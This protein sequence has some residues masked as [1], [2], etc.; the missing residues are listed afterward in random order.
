MTRATMEAVAFARSAGVPTDIEEALSIDPDS[1]VQ[2][3]RRLIV[4]VEPLEQ[5]RRG[6]EIAASALATLRET[7]TGAAALPVP[8]ALARAFAAAN[9]AVREEN[10]L[11]VGEGQGRR[12]DVGATAVVLEGRDLT[13]AQV[14]PT[15]AVVIQDG[16]GY[17]FPCLDSWGPDYLPTIDRPTPQAE[18]LGYAD[19]VC[20]DLYRTVMAPGDLLILC[21][22]GLARCLADEG[23]GAPA[24]ILAASAPLGAD[25]AEVVERLQQLVE[26][27]DLDRAHAACL[28]VGP[29]PGFDLRLPAQAMTRIGDAWAGISSR[30]RL[31]PGNFLPGNGRRRTAWAGV[32]ASSGQ[33]TSRS[34]FALGPAEDDPGAEPI[35]QLI[36]PDPDGILPLPDPVRAVAPVARN[37][38]VVPMPAPVSGGSGVTVPE[39]T[40]DGTPS[41][42]PDDLGSARPNRANP[43]QGEDLA[44][45][46]NTLPPTLS[47]GLAVGPHVRRS[48][49]LASAQ[50]ATVRVM[51][52]IA[53]RR[54]VAA[55][56]GAAHAALVPGALGMRCYRGTASLSDPPA[57]RLNLPR[58][59]VIRVPRRVQIAV[60]LLLIILGGSGLA[61]ER[62]QARLAQISAAFATT[63]EALR[64]TAA[65]GETTVIRAQLDAAQGALDVAADL[66]ADVDEIT[67]R[68][69]AL[70]AARDRTD[71]V[72]RLVE[73]T[74]L[75]ALPPE[76][77]GRSIRLIRGDREIFVVGGGFYRLTPSGD[78]LVQLL[79]P[80][81]EIG[82]TTVGDLRDGAWDATGATVT[83]GAHLYAMD[84]TGAWTRRPMGWPRGGSSWGAG[85]TGA[86]EGS[87]Y[88]LDRRAGQILKFA[89]SEGTKPEEWVEPGFHDDLMTAR[90]VVVDGRIHV[91]LADGRVLSF[92]RGEL[93]ATLTPGVTPALLQPV[94]LYGG[95]DT[96]SLYIVDDGGDAGGRIVQMRRDG[97]G[98][99]QLMLPVSP[100]AKPEANPLAEVQDLVVDEA[101]GTLYFVTGDALWRATL[102]QEATAQPD[103]RHGWGVFGGN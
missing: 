52:R 10:R 59:P 18:P 102:P 4:T 77:T 1:T 19:C 95:P 83:D 78:R 23:I 15:Q 87:F 68:N 65:G 63:D 3:A 33:P 100:N 89:G 26:E 50:T 31:G 20:P 54:P 69:A 99:R 51:E 82:N 88:L 60:L 75:G 38:P 24:N 44:S 13:I 48:Q 84:F 8:A 71:G 7:F 9:A 17:A 29:S 73:V 49:F 46:A 6:S 62:H 97:D 66:G 81:T 2:G 21:S 37:E 103:L 45:L 70:A 92:Y 67:P 43:V 101:S 56:R 55:P 11:Q 34:E 14:P 57:W 85:P 53:P 42:A 25:A 16:Q 39:V 12:V 30:G 91:L 47:D 28:S 41:A 22:A 5:S 58:G 64:V 40:L 72:V 74:R 35:E 61:Y 90:D 94:A 93:E 36:P 27:Y 76:M 98:V 32:A 79:A 96:H 80:G 86:F